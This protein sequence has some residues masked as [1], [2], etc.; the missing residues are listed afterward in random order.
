MVMTGSFWLLN[1][2]PFFLTQKCS[3]RKEFSP[4]DLISI[5]HKV[6]FESKRADRFCAKVVHTQR[7]A[8]VLQAQD[9]RRNGQSREAGHCHRDPHQGLANWKISSRGSHHL[10]SSF[11]SVNHP[12]VCSFERP[13]L[14]NLVPYDFL[15]VFSFV[16]YGVSD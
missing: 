1:L 5:T 9:P 10:F 14:H 8:G 6:L 16:A 15:F 7:L 12:Q 3:L 11:G 4:S 2:D 13:Q